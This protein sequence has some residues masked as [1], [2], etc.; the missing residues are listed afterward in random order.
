MTCGI[1]YDMPAPPRPGRG[2][3]K[4]C[5]DGPESLSFEHGKVYTG[6][7]DL[8]G[9]ERENGILEGIMQADKRRYVAPCALFWGTVMNLFCTICKVAGLVKRS[10]INVL[11]NC[12]IH[13]VVLSAEVVQITEV[14]LLRANWLKSAFN[15]VR[16]ARR[17]CFMRKLRYCWQLPHHLACRCAQRLGGAYV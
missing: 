14:I 6:S 2:S 7:N 12:Y 10:N 8:H 9:F 11:I 15:Y 1:R 17:F 16:G 5:R 4:V 3:V 13:I